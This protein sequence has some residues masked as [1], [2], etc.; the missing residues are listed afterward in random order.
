MTSQFTN[1]LKNLCKNRV[2]TAHVKFINLLKMSIHFRRPRDSS[3]VQILVATLLDYMYFL[4]QIIATTYY[5]KI[6][7][8][9]CVVRYR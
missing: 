3:R 5:M 6:F 9:T 4:C 2:F 1:D 8:E 7:E